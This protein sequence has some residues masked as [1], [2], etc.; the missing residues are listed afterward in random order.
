MEPARL[1]VPYLL[2]GAFHRMTVWCHG[3]P[4][5]AAVLCVHGLTRNGR[6]FDVLA[7][8]LADR[9]FVLCPDLPGRGAS[10]WLADPALYQPLSYVQALSHLLARVGRKVAWVGTSLGGICGM[11]TAAAAAAP[12]GAL[13]LNDVGPELPA[14]ALTRIGAY[15]AQTPRFDDLAALERHLRVIHAPFGPLSDAQWAQ[16]AAT[17][18]RVLPE[19]GLALNYDP[20]IGLAFG[21]A[22]AD[23]D[24]WPVWAALRLPVLAIRGATSDLLAPGVVARMVA[25]GAEAMEVAGAG[26]A[27][28]LMDGPSIA[29]VRDFLLRHHPA[30]ML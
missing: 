25:D 21:G 5:A 11:L 7:G 1:V 3:D 19:G 22:P 23:V 16:M 14:A 18:A 15:L 2:G 9:Y 26:H 27:P 28:A 13:V 6:D 12:V 30:A 20:A 10:D 29:R 4:A 17:S 8:A 24:M